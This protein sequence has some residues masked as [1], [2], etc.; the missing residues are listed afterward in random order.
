MVEVDHGR[1]IVAASPDWATPCRSLE[2]VRFVLVHGAYHGAWCWDALLPHLEER[3]HQVEAVDLPIEDPDAGADAYADVVA[4]VVGDVESVVVGHSMMGLAIPLV[5]ARAQVSRLVFLCAFIPRPGFSFNEVR[6]RESVETDRKVQNVQ[7]T[8]IG[9]N[10]WTIGPDTARELFYH[11]VSPALADRAL[12]QLR[13]QAYRIM[14]EA[15][16]LG[17]WP[18][19]PS[20]YILCRG[21]RAVSPAWARTVARERL[22]VEAM[23]M[24][25]GHSPFLTRPAELAANLDEIV[26][27]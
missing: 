18:D 5:P 26:M 1:V 10:V 11:D 16:P 15:T 8:E 24:D 13:P 23:E 9:D 19:V 27:P 14:S 25:G 20:S 21:D 12:A 6:S 2:P 22:G 4:A 3:G 7:F 17:T